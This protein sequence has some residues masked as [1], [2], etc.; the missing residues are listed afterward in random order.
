MQPLWWRDIATEVSNSLSL[1]LS[2]SLSLSHT[3]TH[4]HTHTLT[5][6]TLLPKQEMAV[7]QFHWIG[8]LQ[9]KNLFLFECSYW[10]QTSQTGDQPYSPLWL[11]FS[12]LTLSSMSVSVN[13]T[14]CDFKFSD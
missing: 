11:V 1:P 13:L 14:V 4:P 3:H 2:L 5:I 10:I 8:F 6:Y 7:F 12:P 9:T